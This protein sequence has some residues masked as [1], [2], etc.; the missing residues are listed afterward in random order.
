[1]EYLE[2]I[3]KFI[4][5]ITNFSLDLK[6]TKEKERKEKLKRYLEMYNQFLKYIKK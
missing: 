6:K 2:F 1:M 4:K 3:R 5:F